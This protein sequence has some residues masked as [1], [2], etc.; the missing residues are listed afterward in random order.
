LGLLKRRF[1]AGGGEKRNYWSLKEVCGVLDNYDLQLKKII[2]FLKGGNSENVV[3]QTSKGKKVLK[4]YYWSLDSTLYEHSI[5]KYLIDI[6]FPC[7]RLTA[8]S[9]GLTYTQLNG[10]HYAVYDFIDGYCCSDYIISAKIMRR[11]ISQAG[12][13]LAQYHRLM[14]NFK[15]PQGKKLNG[16]RPDGIK[17]WRGAGWHM[18]T[19]D[20]Y[21][22]KNPEKN[23]H[24]MR[25]N[26]L[27]QI[28]SKLKI[29]YLTTEKY[30]EKPDSQLPKLV[31]HG[32]YKPGN[33]LFSQQKISGILDFGDASLNLRVLDVVRG[34]STF[35]ND[36]KVILDLNYCKIFLESYS[37]FQQLTQKEINAIPELLKRWYLNSIIWSLHGDMKSHPNRKAP[38]KHL[39]SIL[40]KWQ[41][42]ILV[43]QFDDEF[44]SSLAIL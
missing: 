13:K 31:I 11:L 24:D 12:K 36:K 2:N 34:L 6:N 16:F 32:D 25:V 5:L 23:G 4:R 14:Q 38:E 44:R 8:N 3:I 41:K 10:S 20:K 29:E 17:L 9:E 35:C 28:K 42:A 26:F 33:V 40:R 22:E 1:K 15:M 30:F 21:L 27:H 43:K 19:L 37:A 18:K 7:C 39:E